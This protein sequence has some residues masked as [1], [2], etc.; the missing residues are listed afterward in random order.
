[1]LIDPLRD[2]P[3]YYARDLIKSAVRSQFREAE[4]IY[5]TNMLSHEREL[6]FG[7]FTLRYMADS[8]DKLFPSAIIFLYTPGDGVVSMLSTWC[9]RI[10]GCC[11]YEG[12]EDYLPGP[13][14]SAPPSAFDEPGEN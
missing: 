5:V 9:L 13:R 4:L 10:N 1:M 11:D 14:E 12:A 6:L 7:E 2:A 3:I 8:D